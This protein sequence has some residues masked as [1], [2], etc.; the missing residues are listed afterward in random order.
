MTTHE[1]AV[2]ELGLVDASSAG[3]PMFSPDRPASVQ[4][5]Q[6]KVSNAAGRTLADAV[7]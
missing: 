2:L 1:G 5:A 3:D 4:A 7:M 6:G